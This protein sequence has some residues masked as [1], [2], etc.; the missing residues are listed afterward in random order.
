M[1]EEI[2]I[3]KEEVYKLQNPEDK[4]ILVKGGSSQKKEVLAGP[5]QTVSNKRNKEERSIGHTGP[6]QSPGDETPKR[7][8]CGIFQESFHNHNF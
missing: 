8:W 1:G 7:Y 6:L 3:L 5:P 2:D 4:E